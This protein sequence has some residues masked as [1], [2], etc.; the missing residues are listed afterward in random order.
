M[1]VYQYSKTEFF[2]VNWAVFY[3]YY[4]AS[5]SDPEF[6]LYTRNTKS[7]AL[8]SEHAKRLGIGASKKVK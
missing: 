2:Y 6:E 5:L 3:C 7:T 4:Q 8:A 1:Y